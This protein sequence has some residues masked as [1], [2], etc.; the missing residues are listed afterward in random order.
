MDPT[1]LVIDDATDSEQLLALRVGG[2]TAAPLHARSGEEGI[3]LARVAQPDLVLLDAR[4]PDIGGLEVCERL[5]GCAETWSIPVIFVSD[6][7][8]VAA[9]VRAFDCGAIDYVT[10]PFD[11]AELQVRM[12]TALRSK[13][14]EDLLATKVRIDM[15]TGMWNRGHFEARLAEELAAWKRYGR[16]L[17]IVLIDIDNFQRFNELHGHPSG[18]LALQR[19]A[20][21]LRG[22]VR[23]TDTASRCGGGQFAIML[24]ESGM[25][26][27]A[28]YARRLNK[29]FQALSFGADGPRL[30]LTTSI[31]VAASELWEKG[32][33]LDVARIMARVDYALYKAKRSGRNRIEL[34]TAA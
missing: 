18:D 26:G 31:G 28:A 29:L 9:R 2:S 11:L 21:C 20:E 14:C 3:M 5:K 15:L 32:A 17:A 12:R 33:P 34:A 19:L 10:R 4:L 22:C 6:P 16:Q 27:A 13:Q 24:R 1:V 30:G 23:K 25:S 7:V 8:D